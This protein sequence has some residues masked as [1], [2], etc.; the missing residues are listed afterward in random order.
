MAALALEQASFL[1][2]GLLLWVA[3][4]GQGSAPSRDRAAAGALALLLT[5]IH[6]TLLGVL[7]AMATRVLYPHAGHGG[8]VEHLL[9]DQQAGGVLMLLIGGV[10]YLVG[11]L[12][13]LRRLLQ[14]MREAQG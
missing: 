10:S 6:M 12:V 3:A 13:L 11:A 8:G 1:G 5:A 4:L 2:A 9:R 14:P 7:L